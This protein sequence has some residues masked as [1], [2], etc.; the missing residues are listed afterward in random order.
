MTSRPAASRG[1]RRRAKK[2]ARPVH[3][4]DVLLVGITDK[5]RHGEVDFGRPLGKERVAASA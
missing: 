5:N 2:I 3:A 4:L 1:K